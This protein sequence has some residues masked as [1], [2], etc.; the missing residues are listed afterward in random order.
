M[1]YDLDLTQ[2]QVG[3]TVG[4]A[5]N[6]DLLTA[7][8]TSGGITVTSITIDP[9]YLWIAH[10]DASAEPDMTDSWPAYWNQVDW[11]TGD[12]LPTPPNIDDGEPPNNTPDTTTYTLDLADTTLGWTAG[13]DIRADQ[14]SQY[15][16]DKG[17]PAQ[18]VSLDHDGAGG[19]TGQIDV[20]RLASGAT[21][22]PTDWAAYNG[23]ASV[24][25]YGQTSV[26]EPP[27]NAADDQSP[28][29]GTR[30]G[31]GSNASGTKSTAIGKSAS[32]SNSS[33]TAIG[34]NA[35][36]TNA[37][38]IA[39]GVDTTASGTEAIAI[40]V[41]ALA[42]KSATI[43]IGMQAQA[44]GSQGVAIGYQAAANTASTAMGTT[45]QATGI[46]AAAYGSG[47][48]ATGVTST[49]IG[50][51]AIANNSSTLALGQTAL[52][53]GNL[54]SAIGT[55]SQALGAFSVAIGASASAS[56]VGATAV[57]QAA[58]ASGGGSA[59][60]GKNAQATGT[61]STAIGIAS[62]A[63][64]DFA[65]AL[66]NS[67][68]ASATFALSLGT[69]SAGTGDHGIAIGV[70]A[71]TRSK[72]GIALGGNATVDAS[73]PYSMAIGYSA[74]VPVSTPFQ[75]IWMASDFRVDTP[76][77]ASGD[78]A[79]SAE[80]TTITLRSPDAT[81]GTIAVTNTDGITVN[82]NALATASALA[83]EAS[84]R[85]TNDGTLA[86]AIST[87]TTN[88]TNA[89]S[90]EVTNRN[91][92]IATHAA[93]TATHG[94]TGAVVGTTNTQ[95][96]T[97]KTL[98][99]PT[100]ADLTNMQ[101]DH[102]AANKGGTLPQSSITGLVAALAAKQDDLIE[103]TG[104]RTGTS[105]QTS[106]GATQGTTFGS[107]VTQVTTADGYDPAKAYWVTIS[108]EIFVTL[109]S[110]QQA[111]VAP[112]RQDLSSL[113][114]GGF[115]LALSTFLSEQRISSSWSFH[116]LANGLPGG[117]G[118]AANVLETRLQFWCSGTGT[119][120]FRDGTTTVLMVP[121]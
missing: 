94:A 25:T 104:P 40:G 4:A 89:D 71:T 56:G 87:E 73:S 69:G 107:A 48:Q 121:V 44:T 119:I 39:M 3:Y 85:S 24:T 72:Y 117:N 35:Q 100:I 37:D 112:K 46:S 17:A 114:I 74:Y 105:T 92:A 110:G 99:A 7:W 108:A 16:T 82:G 102:S 76:L 45:A 15:L 41:E 58:T 26:G 86:T 91:A 21:I 11:Q 1:Q 118:V 65:A 116:L 53:S 13:S 9:V 33:T 22:S 5:F 103:K 97:N 96:L 67:A 84:T 18:S 23:P 66:G 101:H 60:Y 78:T 62:Q 54:A 95:T 81:L 27:I 43:A 34:D 55:A 8:L 63:T 31:D 79:P 28:Q 12:P 52:A 32:A 38:A 113:G 50:Q 49:A 19:L 77:V 98:T 75:T 30:Y 20:V 36:A 2:T 83:S 42:S 61:S 70:P 57:G 120:N 106:S 47:A 6:V 111:A 64:A 29:Q 90:T 115:E 109:A 59:A 88:R 51:G 14:I 93:L 10:V 80:S 68:V